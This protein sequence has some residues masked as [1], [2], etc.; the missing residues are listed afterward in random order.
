MRMPF[1]KRVETICG[2][3]HTDVLLILSL[4]CKLNPLVDGQES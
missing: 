1:V 2:L 3:T 4:R